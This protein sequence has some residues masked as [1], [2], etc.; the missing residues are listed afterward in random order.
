MLIGRGVGVI[1]AGRG[2]VLLMRLVVRVVVVL[3]LIGVIV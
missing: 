3:V 1:V 2:K